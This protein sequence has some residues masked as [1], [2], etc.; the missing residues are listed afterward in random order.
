MASYY[1]RPDLIWIP[2]TDV[3]PLRVAIA[4]MDRNP[5]PLVAEFT[6]LVR[7]LAAAGR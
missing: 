5:D 7:E 1:G 3:E 6:A 4:H 2:I